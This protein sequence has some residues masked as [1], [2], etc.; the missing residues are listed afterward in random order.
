MQEII[1]TLKQWGIEI[2]QT[3]SLIIIFGIIFL[4]AIILHLVLHHIVLRAFEKKSPG[5][6]AFV[7]TDY[8]TE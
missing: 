3:T 2:N 7:V 4:T 8:H 6:P 5:Q 1:V